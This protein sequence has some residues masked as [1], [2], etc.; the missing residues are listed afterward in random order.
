MKAII[1][2]DEH[3]NRLLVEAMLKKHCPEVTVLCDASS[4][5]DAYQKIN[6]LQPNLIF[7][8]VKMPNKSGF[9]LLRMF[10]N[11]GFYVI[12]ITGFEEY[13]I[14]A[15]EFC[16][17]DYLL[18]PIDHTKLIKAVEKVKQKIKEEK[19][20]NLLHFVHSLEEK[21]NLLKRITLHSND[22]VNII[23]LKDISFIVANRGYCEI[24]TIS[25]QR[26]VS[27]KTLTDYE[28]LLAP[29]ENF[30]RVHK[31][32]LINIDHVLSYTKG[33]EC[34]IEMRGGNDQIEVSR[35]K[36]TEIILLL[37]RC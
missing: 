37:K 24:I 12:F 6:L 28:D 31:S 8:D 17:V 35:R 10:D 30:V 13:A 36:K 14:N 5:D 15:F 4:A 2:D 23:E 9:D 27:A 33:N 1:I 34:L 32:Y 7:L 26:Y 25:N 18:K 19:N 11:I 3:G 20:S 22:K 21:T 16:A 29:I